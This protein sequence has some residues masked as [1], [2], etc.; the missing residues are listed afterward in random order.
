MSAL[1]NRLAFR[2]VNSNDTA[3]STVVVTLEENQI[4]FFKKVGKLRNYIASIVRSSKLQTKL[5]L[6]KSCKV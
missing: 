2:N 5:K 4:N 1:Q 6:S 3:S